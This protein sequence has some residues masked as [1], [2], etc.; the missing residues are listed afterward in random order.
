MLSAQQ[1]CVRHDHDHVRQYL[2]AALCRHAA[3]PGGTLGFQVLAY[4]GH[5]VEPQLAEARQARERLEVVKEG[6]RKDRAAADAHLGHGGGGRT[7]A[8]SNQQSQ[9]TSSSKHVKARDDMRRGSEISKDAERDTYEWMMDGS[10]RVGI[11][12]EWD[13]STARDEYWQIY[14]T[15]RRVWMFQAAKNANKADADLLA[16]VLAVAAGIC[17]R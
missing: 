12:R 10:T 15:A 3:S 13:P 16:N 2:L 14:F 5:G 8:K 11:K 6:S 17:S 1:P 4:E 7:R 9:R